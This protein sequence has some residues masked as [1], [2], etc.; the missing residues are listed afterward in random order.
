MKK[1]SL[2]N[3]GVTLISDEDYSEV[4]KYKWFLKRETHKE[5]VIR[6]IGKISLSRFL[7]N[8]PKG[9]L[10]D[11]IDGNRLNNQRENIRICTPAENARN[12]ILYSTNTSGFRGVMW[13]KS[14]KKWHARITVN[15]KRISLGFFDSITDAAK[16]YNKAAKEY[17]GEFARLNYIGKEQ[18]RK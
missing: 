13:K 8:P 2:T 18:E 9:M 5:S 14:N 15:Y 17:F 11:H 3:G 4:S 7:L 16:A 6:T 10:V 1:I 12:T